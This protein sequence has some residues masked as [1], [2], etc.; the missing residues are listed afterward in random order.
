MKRKIISTIAFL[1]L[2]AGI[3]GA[4]M[5]VS[6]AP[7]YTVGNASTS[8]WYNVLSMY[9]PTNGPHAVQVQPYYGLGITECG[10]TTLEAVGWTGVVSITTG[11]SVQDQ[12][13]IITNIMLDGVVTNTDIRP[14]DKK[15]GCFVHYMSA[16][17]PTNKLVIDQK[18]MNR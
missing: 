18:A 14:L 6:I 9:Y 1:V 8:Q 2:F 4:G 15:V 13:T 3:V 7:T 5:F 10:E 11:P 17:N 12:T 16:Y